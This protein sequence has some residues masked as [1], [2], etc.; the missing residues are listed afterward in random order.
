MLLKCVILGTGAWE[1]EGVGDSGG[2]TGQARCCQGGG[3]EPAGAPP[4]VPRHGGD[5]GGPG[6]AARR[7]PPPRHQRLP[8]RQ[9]WGQQPQDC[10][11]VP[12]EQPPVDVHRNRPPPHFNSRC[13]HSHGP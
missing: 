3:E 4:G 9:W 5:G 6:G 11:A 13:H 2:D 8:I 12:A 1:G 7:H 10:Q